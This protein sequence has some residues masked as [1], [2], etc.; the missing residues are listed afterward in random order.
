[1]ERRLWEIETEGGLFFVVL[2]ETKDDAEAI[3]REVLDDEGCE[4]TSYDVTGINNGLRVIHFESESEAREQVSELALAGVKR[5]EI[6]VTV[7]LDTDFEP[8]FWAVGT[9]DNNW[10]KLRSGFLYGQLE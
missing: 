4:L 2:A 10:C 5:L 8:L 3:A 7:S 6:K 9:T 1:M